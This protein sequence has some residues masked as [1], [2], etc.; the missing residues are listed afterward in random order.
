MHNE[1]S[2]VSSS[3]PSGLLCEDHNLSS[4]LKR[5][6]EHHDRDD[7]TLQDIVDAVGMRGFGILIVLLALPSALPVPAVGYSMPFGLLLLLLSIQIA[8]GHRVPWMPQWALKLTIRRSFAEK[9]VSWACAFLSRFEKLIKRRLEW[10]TARP[11]RIFAG[12][13]IS[14]MACLMM[15]P[16]PF[17][18][19]FPAFV[20]FLVGV[21][22]TERDGF[23]FI[24]AAI[25]G[26]LAALFYTALVY[27][28]MVYG[29][30]AVTG[31]VDTL[32]GR[33]Q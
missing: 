5:I 20:I 16:I 32:L 23:M 22:M 3:Q 4:D 11:G 28:A 2:A 14:L 10:A 19:T 29:V 15:V 31:F 17:T 33:S 30:D 7:I 26:A 21:G 1:S 24:G 8:L 27:V 9:I 6:L 12:I 13:V 25:L 18:N